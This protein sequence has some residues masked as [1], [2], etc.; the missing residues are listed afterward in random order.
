MPSRSRALELQELVNDFV[1]AVELLT[2]RVVLALDVE[3]LTAPDHDETP[4][5]ASAGDTRPERCGAAIAR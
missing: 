2:G 4:A 5:T 3:L 1:A